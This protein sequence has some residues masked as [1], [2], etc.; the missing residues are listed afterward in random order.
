MLLTINTTLTGSHSTHEF[1]HVARSQA[2]N[3][4]MR[5]TGDIQPQKHIPYVSSAQ[6]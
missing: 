5:Q 3:F 1:C 2:T 6:K 4:E